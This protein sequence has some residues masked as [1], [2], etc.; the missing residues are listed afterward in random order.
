MRSGGGW[1]RGVR[2]GVAWG[3]TR[4]RQGAL[5]RRRGIADEGLEMGSEEWGVKEWGVEVG[6]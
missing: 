2:G 5:A 1:S 4:S 6:V 3:T